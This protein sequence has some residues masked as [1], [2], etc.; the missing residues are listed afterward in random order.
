[1]NG[2]IY[3]VSFHLGGVCSLEFESKACETQKREP[4]RVSDRFWVEHNAAIG[5]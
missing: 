3:L 1:M 5:L 4:T 2:P